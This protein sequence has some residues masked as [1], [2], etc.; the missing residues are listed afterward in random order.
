MSGHCPKCGTYCE[1]DDDR[2][3]GACRT[4]ANETY[5]DI[6]NARARIAT[7]ETALAA[8]TAERDKAIRERDE[9]RHGRTVANGDIAKAC[10][11][12]SAR[13]ACELVDLWAKALAAMTKERDDQAEAVRVLGHEGRECFVVFARMNKE[14]M[15]KHLHP[16]TDANPIARAAMEGER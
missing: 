9:A 16:K 12:T 3:C 2:F 6:V 5:S 10:S 14:E 7:L 1:E 13:T 8:M 11:G 4:K 15:M